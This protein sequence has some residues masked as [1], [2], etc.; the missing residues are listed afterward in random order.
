LERL[1][2]MAVSITDLA[3]EEFP[4][5]ESRVEALVEELA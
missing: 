2:Q 1:F 4:E 3:I 5:T